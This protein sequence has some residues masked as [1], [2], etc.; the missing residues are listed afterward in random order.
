MTDVAEAIA[1]IEPIPAPRGRL[2][3]AQVKR[4]LRAV[5]SDKI[6]SKNG[7][8]YFPQHEARAELIRIFGPGGADH[9]MTKPELVYERQIKTG[10][11]DYPK[12]PKVAGSTYYVACYMVGCDLYVYDYEGRLV[13]NCMEWHVEENMP[14]PNRGEA[15][16]MAATSAQSYALRR[17]LLSLGDAFGLHLYDKGSKKPII[18]RTYL[19]EDKDSPLYQA[20]DPAKPDAATAGTARMQAAINNPEA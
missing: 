9:K 13:Y 16:A 6:E 12:N 1:T 8:S 3:R 5:E 17:S 15:H 14:L 20:P 10:E 11:P 18:G 2:T 4:L 7:L 19:L